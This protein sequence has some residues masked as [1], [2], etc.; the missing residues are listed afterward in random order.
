MATEKMPSEHYRSIAR[1]EDSYWWHQARFEL[2][3]KRI[4]H[5][6]KRPRDLRV[7]DVGCG[8]GGFLRFLSRKGFRRLK[9]VDASKSALAVVEESGI[10][11]ECL[12]LEAGGGLGEG[13]F[14]VVTALLDVLEHLDVEERLLD[15]IHSSLVSEG[16]TFITVPAHPA[17]FSD[18]DRRL[19]HFRRYSR[20]HLVRLLSGHGFRVL[21]S[22][23][24]FSFVLPMALLR[25]WV[26]AYSGAQ[27]CE[28]PEVSVRTSV[29]L[30]H[31]AGLERLWLEKRS[32]PAGTS[33]Y[34]LAER[35]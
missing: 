26:G 33:L 8:S 25:R 4:E 9:G 10:E 5:H 15:A 34:V 23:Y 21:E 11:A 17:L 28:F 32:L 19:K 22:S 2:A 31:A 7:A 16:L 27:S 35:L 12:D 3:V 20:G 6:R 30:A 24:F 14:D 29:A 13:R 18:W 1:I